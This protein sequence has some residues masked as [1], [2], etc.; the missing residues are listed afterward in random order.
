MMF[1]ISLLT[2]FLLASSI[3]AWT[4]ISRRDAMGTLATGLVFGPAVNTQALE[5]SV[6][7]QWTPPS[8]DTTSKKDAALIFRAALE[9]FP[10]QAPVPANAGAW[11]LVEDKL[12][13]K[14]TARV[15]FKSSGKPGDFGKFLGSNKVRERW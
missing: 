9:T 5:G 13:G 7:A 1:R 2:L 4:T 10:Q 3:D 11:T 12:E 8:G 14:G 15:E 6:C